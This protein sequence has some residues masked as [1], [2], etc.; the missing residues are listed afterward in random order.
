MNNS[1]LKIGALIFCVAIGLAIYF[2]PAT[3]KTNQQ[4]NS[5]DEKVSK[6]VALVQ[7]GNQPMAGIKLLQEVVAEDPKH[8]EANYQLGLFSVQSQQWEKG[9]NRFNTVKEVG[10]FDKYEDAYY[11]HAL[12]YASIDSLERAK[13]ILTEGLEVAQDSTL[14]ETLN[15]FRNTIIN[16]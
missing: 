16:L 2:L 7:F 4:V 8:L 9:V 12:C 3:P 15:Q 13:S 11:Y 5:L 10:G 6:A 1:I 14:R